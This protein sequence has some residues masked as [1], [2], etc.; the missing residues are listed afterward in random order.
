MLLATVQVYL[1]TFVEI[2]EQYQVS[3]VP[4][5]YFGDGLSNTNFDDPLDYISTPGTVSATSAPEPASLVSF[6]TALALIAI[7]LCVRRTAR[8]GGRWPFA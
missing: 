2:G 3:L 1:Q 8:Q 4:Q 5:Q 6:M 7:F